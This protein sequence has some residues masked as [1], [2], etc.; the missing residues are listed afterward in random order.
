MVLHGCTVGL[1]VV[2]AAAMLSDAYGTKVEWIHQMIIDLM[3]PNNYNNNVYKDSYLDN[4]YRIVSLV[5][6]SNVRGLSNQY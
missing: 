1:I 4:M 2:G 6:Y 5:F 3:D